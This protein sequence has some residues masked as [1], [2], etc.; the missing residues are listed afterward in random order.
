M[1]KKRKLTANDEANSLMSWHIKNAQKKHPASKNL[2]R[3][4]Q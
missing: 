3:K 2:L 1:E 4:N